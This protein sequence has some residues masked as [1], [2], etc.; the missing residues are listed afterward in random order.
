M[1]DWEIELEFHIHDEYE[2]AIRLA[3]GQEHV[4]EYT[5]DDESYAQDVKEFMG[6][7]FSEAEWE[8]VDGQ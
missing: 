1:E 2:K 6:D 4:E 7:E 8:E 3:S 5:V